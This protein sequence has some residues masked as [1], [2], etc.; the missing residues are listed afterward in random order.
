[1]SSLSKRGPRGLRDA[2][3]IVKFLNGSYMKST[4]LDYTTGN[5]EELLNSQAEESKTKPSKHNRE[6]ARSSRKLIP[7][8]FLDTLRDALNVELPTLLFNYIHLHL[9][10][11][12]LVD[13]LK[14]RFRHKLPALL[15]DWY[16]EDRSNICFDIVSV[17]IDFGSPLVTRSQWIEGQRTVMEETSIALNAMIDAAGGQVGAESMGWLTD[18]DLGKVTEAG[19]LYFETH[20]SILAADMTGKA[21]DEDDANVTYPTVVDRSVIVPPSLP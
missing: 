21:E 20:N 1:M 5:I 4:S 19:V 13:D 8:D 16:N 17:A 14:H 12:M 6:L 10:S 3:P 9:N 2:T 11:Q 7:Q 15:G 18:A